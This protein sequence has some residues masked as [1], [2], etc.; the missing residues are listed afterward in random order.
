MLEETIQ[1][2]SWIKEKKQPGDLNKKLKQY[3][4]DLN[5]SEYDNFMRDEV[6]VL[7]NLHDLFSNPD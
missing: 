6:G 2:S 3:D 7:R 5:L 4:K 1:E